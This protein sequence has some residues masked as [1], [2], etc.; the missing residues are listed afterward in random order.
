M[1]AVYLKQAFGFSEAWVKKTEHW[2]QN[3]MNESVVK[4][5]AS[6]AKKFNI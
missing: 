6:L 5:K 2:V 1:T 4:L 3:S